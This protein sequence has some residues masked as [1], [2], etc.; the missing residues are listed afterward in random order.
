VAKPVRAAE[1]PEPTDPEPD[2]GRPIRKASR[3]QGRRPRADDDRADEL[4]RPTGR[5]RRSW[6]KVQL[7]LTVNQIVVILRLVTLLVLFV[8]LAGV[9]S[10]VKTL[11]D[12]LPVVGLFF[13]TLVPLAGPPKQLAVA[14]FAVAVVTSVWLFLTAVIRGWHLPGLA[15]DL[16]VIARD[17]VPIFFLRAIAASLR[18]DDLSQSSLALVIVRLTQLVFSLLLAVVP[19]NWKQSCLPWFGTVLFLAGLLMEF[20]LLAKVRS[21]LDVYLD[22]DG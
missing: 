3:K 6:R 16:L 10:T 18:S 12:I 20:R 9:G 4:P 22:D 21:L 13:Y 11:C 17:I 15:T 2:A 5:Q 14:G 1:S 7:G 19:E 8:P